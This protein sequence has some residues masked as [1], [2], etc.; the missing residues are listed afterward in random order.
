METLGRG[1][2]P[3]DLLFGVRDKEAVAGFTAPSW[4]EALGTEPRWHG[5]RRRFATWRAIL[6]DPVPVIQRWLGHKSITTTMSYIPKSPMRPWCGGPTGGGE[7][8]QFR[9]SAEYRPGGVPEWLIGVALKTSPRPTA[10]AAPAESALF[11]RRTLPT[12][13]HLPTWTG[14]PARAPRGADGERRR[15]RR[16]RGV[17]SGGPFLGLRRA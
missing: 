11:R 1:R 16:C 10:Y 3:E 9:N 17:R 7:R 5:L 2:G 6:G 13:P 14:G 4:R 8:G 12:V 15:S